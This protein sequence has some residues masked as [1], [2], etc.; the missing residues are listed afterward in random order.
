MSR[1]IPTAPSRRGFLAVLGAGAAS[2]VI[3]AVGAAPVD[4]TF[5]A[6]KAEREAYAAY[7]ATGEVQSRISDQDPDPIAVKPGAV[8]RKRRK[9]AAVKA[10]W[11]EYKE[12]EAV[13][14]KSCQEFWAA[15]ETLLQTQPTTVAGLR[16]YLDHIDGPFSHGEAGEAFWDDDERELAFP[17]LAAAVR[18]LVDGMAQS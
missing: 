9:T 14:E 18:S 15:R 17:T 7:L 3:P 5:A 1:S 12:A 11:A 6:I 13:H 4:P 8:P 16:A 2:A 10:W